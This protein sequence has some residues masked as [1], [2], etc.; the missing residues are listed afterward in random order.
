M[1]Q[2][3]HFFSPA[4]PVKVQLSLSMP[5]KNIAGAEV[6]LQPFFTQPWMV[7][8][9]QHHAPAA[10]PPGKD[11]RYPFN[12]R[13]GVPRRWVWT[14]GTGEKSLAPAEIRTPH[15]PARN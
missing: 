7:M 14:V 2:N 10:L 5:Q 8:S 12:R 1:E 11:H 3:I 4:G 13:L 15:R 6:Q 9:G